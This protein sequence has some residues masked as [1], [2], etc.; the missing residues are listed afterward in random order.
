MMTLFVALIVPIRLVAQTQN[1][2]ITKRFEG[3]FAVVAV[4]PDVRLAS[5]PASRLAGTSS[6]DN[7]ERTTPAIS[8]HAGS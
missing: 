5:A 2:V 8:A 1:Y 3:L 7:H 6:A 4:T